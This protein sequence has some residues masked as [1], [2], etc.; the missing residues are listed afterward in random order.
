MPTG[1]CFVAPQGVCCMDCASPLVPRSAADSGS[2]KAAHCVNPLLLRKAITSA[3][4]AIGE[5]PLEE[6]GCY[7]ATTVPLLRPSM[8]LPH[9][10]AAEPPFPFNHPDVQ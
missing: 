8:L 9:S 4:M 10:P 6:S 7:W 2:G 3:A 5:A 1:M